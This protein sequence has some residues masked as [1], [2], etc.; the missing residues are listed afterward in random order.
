MG[1]YPSKIYSRA[2]RFVCYFIFFESMVFCFSEQI[3]VPLFTDTLN[4][5]K[6]LCK[7]D[8]VICISDIRASHC[9]TF[10]LTW[11][12]RASRTVLNS[13]CLQL[14]VKTNL[15]VHARHLHQITCPQ[16][17]L[18]TALSC[19]ECVWW[20]HPRCTECKWKWTVVSNRSINE[21]HIYVV[22]W[23]AWIISA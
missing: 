7:N 6:I 23:R 5:A 10:P 17:T 22:V 4:I 19:L 2:P 3:S 12:Q 1:Y 21:Q 15:W 14:L 16:V 13:L 8:N 20:V 11:P 9:W 18:T